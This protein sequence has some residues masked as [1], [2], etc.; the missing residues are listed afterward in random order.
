MLHFVQIS[1]QKVILQILL[2]NC[3]DQKIFKHIIYISHRK[4]L[5][6]IT[7]FYPCWQIL[8]RLSG[9]ISNI[10]AHIK[11]GLSSSPCSTV[12]HS[13][14]SSLPQHLPIILQPILLWLNINQCVFCV[15]CVVCFLI[16]YGPWIF[17]FL[18]II[19]PPQLLGR[20]QCPRPQQPF[21][22]NVITRKKVR[23]SF[24]FSNLLSWSLTN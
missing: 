1:Y 2:Y 17:N 12:F 11:P 9:F 19:I 3:I 23:S 22:A 7:K 8:T 5:T 4:G 18:F 14:C 21:R 13:H 20:N 16:F 24:F 10:M 15:L 6:A